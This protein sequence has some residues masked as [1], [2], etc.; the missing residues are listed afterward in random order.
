MNCQKCNIE[1]TLVPQ[2]IS[3]KT[4]KPYSAFYSCP[5]RCGTT[6]PAVARTS[7]PQS[8]QNDLN[9]NND[10]YDLLTTIVAQNKRILEIVNSLSLLDNQETDFIKDI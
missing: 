6:A 5:N 10:V 9:K 8:P 1:M 7:P 3:R 2:G 4:G